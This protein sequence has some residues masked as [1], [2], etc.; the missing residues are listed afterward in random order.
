MKGAEEVQQVETA[1]LGLIKQAHILGGQ[2]ATAKDVVRTSRGGGGGVPHAFR[3]PEL[4][5]FPSKTDTSGIH[6]RATVGSCGLVTNRA[7][8]ANS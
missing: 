6:Q 1:L 7:G 5:M 2:K 3:Q 8:C 4:R